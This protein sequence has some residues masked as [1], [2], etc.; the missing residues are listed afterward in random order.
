M[1]NLT[2]FRK[3][4]A[5]ALALPVIFMLT[6]CSIPA[7]PKPTS[8]KEYVQASLDYLFHESTESY[9]SIV[10]ISKKHAESTRAETIRSAL[11]DEASDQLFQAFLA[12]YE[13]AQYEV[14]EVKRREDGS[15]LVILRLYP[16]TILP[17]ARSYMKEIL[18]AQPSRSPVQA[19]ELLFADC[20]NRAS[21]N[22]QYLDPVSFRFVIVPEKGNESQLRI[23]A[24]HLQAIETILFPPYKGSPYE[25]KL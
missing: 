18:T 12:M 14:E 21:E 7:C 22:C 15:Y 25:A 23:S 20:L 10:G 2:G 1:F 4:K 9:A 17:L 13:K 6:G 11:P 8:P 16:C 5:A 19:P 3:Y 24:E